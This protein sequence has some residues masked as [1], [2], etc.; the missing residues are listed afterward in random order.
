LWY[1]LVPY[2]LSPAV[3]ECAGHMFLPR[4]CRAISTD[5]ERVRIIY[6]GLVEAYDQIDVSRQ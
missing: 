1:G 5:I 3:V 2:S 4:Y 6:D